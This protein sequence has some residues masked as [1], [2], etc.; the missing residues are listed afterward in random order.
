MLKVWFLC[1]AISLIILSGCATT[2]MNLLKTNPYQLSDDELLRYYY[3]LDGEIRNL[4]IQFGGYASQNS[5]TMGGS[6]ALGA[7]EG[8]YQAQLDALRQRKVDVLME[9]K[10]RSLNP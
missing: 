5:Y 8:A 3:I 7:M 1:L 9:L 6:M 4:E 2:T 10:R